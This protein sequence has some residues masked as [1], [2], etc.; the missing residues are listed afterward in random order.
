MNVQVFIMS[1][2]SKRVTEHC[3]IFLI[4]N[5]LLCEPGPQKENGEIT[6]SS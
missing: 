3:A 1:I 2:K 4:S 6:V 5:Q